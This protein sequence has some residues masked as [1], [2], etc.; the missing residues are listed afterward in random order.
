MRFLEKT[1]RAYARTGRYVYTDW[2]GLSKQ[3]VQEPHI[4]PEFE[5]GAVFHQTSIHSINV[6][7][8]REAVLA[9]GGFDESMVSWE[10]VDFFMRLAAAGYCGVRVPEPLVL[11]RYQTGSLREHGETIKPTLLALL[12]GRYSDFMEGRKVCSC[13]D[14]VKKKTQQQFAASAAGNGKGEL[15]R[16]EFVGPI[17]Q[18]PVVGSITRQNYGRR[19]NGDT[20]YVYAVDQKETPDRFVKIAEVEDVIANTPMPPEPQLMERITA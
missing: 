6:L 2:V 3:G 7:I 15:V 10:D 17:G 16:I 8:P 5:V 12:R 4:T 1:L 14:P 9:V 13:N 18:A 19:A 11:Y 20:F